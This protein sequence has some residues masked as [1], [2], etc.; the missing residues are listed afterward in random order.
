[1][2]VNKKYK[3]LLIQLP[4]P[5]FLIRKKWGNVPLAAGYLKAMAYKEGLLNKVDME[6]LGEKDTNL[7]SDSKLIDLIILKSPDMLAFSLYSWNSIRS[8]YIA[9]EVKKKLP[10][11]KIIVGGPEVTLETK[12]ILNNPVVNIGC[13]GEGE[14]T[15]VE[16]IK[17]VFNGQNDY[18]NVKGI[19]YRKY[20]KI[21]VTPRRE[22]IKDLNIIPSP[23]ISGFINPKD[24]GEA[25]IENMRGC[26][27]KCKFCTWKNRPLGYFSIE[28]NVEEIKVI[29]AKGVNY[30]HIMNSNFTLMPDFEKFCNRLA[31]INKEKKFSCYAWLSAEQ[32][33]EKKADLLQACG[34]TWVGIGLQSANPL[35]LAR[36]GRKLDLSRFVKGC[37]L[38]MEKNITIEIEII[39]GLPCDTLKDFKRT[40]NFLEKNKLGHNNIISPFLLMLHPQVPLR[41]ELKKYGIKYQNKPPYFITETSYISKDEIKKA[42]TLAGGKRGLNFSGS[43]TSYYNIEYPL[44]RNKNLENLKIKP[45]DNRINKVILD[46][47]SSY[48]S[49]DQ[50]EQAG[51]KISRAISDPFTVWFKTQNVEKDFA[52]MSSFLLPIAISNPFLL[53]WIILETNNDFP[54]SIIERIKRNI[55][56]KRKIN[57][58]CQTYDAIETCIIFSWQNN[59]KK[60]LSLKDMSKLIPFFW[61]FNISNELDWQREIAD[62]FREKYS[63]GIL[64]DFDLKSKPDFIVN[65]LK[66]LYKEAKAQHKNILFRNLAIN[67]MN[68]T[69]QPEKFKDNSI[70]RPRYI[71]S[72]LSIDRDMNILPTLKPD[73]ETAMDLIEYQIKLQRR[74]YTLVI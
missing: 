44:L 10:N 39:I 41:K 27:F 28:R 36:I 53:W 64:I 60:E 16:I 9:Q 18:A 1:M 38:L 49:T 47:D 69:E 30:A 70:R 65:V 59:R 33:D 42:I 13:I 29:M 48:Q 26:Q 73:N 40:L 67:Y 37:H 34:C 19:F 4:F 6:I 14:I 45:L 20:D 66:F 17:S 57:D 22:P 25:W 55:P 8:L 71:E 52:L 62:L 50:L 74:G 43:L 2:M 46:L 5:G 72:I 68:F 61:S 11:I 58:T 23:Y 15:F 21:I 31:Q 7:S 51:E 54:I 35:T 63:A 12:Y 32:I 24:Y 3:I 56:L